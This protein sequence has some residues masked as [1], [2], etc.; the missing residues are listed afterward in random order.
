M[1][2]SRTA[3]TLPAVRPNT[4][5]HPLG[6]RL[7]QAGIPYLFMLPYL[8]AFFFFLFLPALAGAGISLTDW[9]ILGTPNFVGL[10]NYETVLGDRMFWLALKNTLAFTAITVIPMVA[11]GLLLAVLLNQKLRG[12][13]LTRTVIF[14]PYA[15]MV[16]VVG[17]LWR[18][19]YDR[20]FGLANFYITRPFGAAPIAWLTS[21]EWAL[22]AVAITT[23]W[24]QIGTNMVIYLAGLQEIPEELYDAAKVD[25]ANALQRLVHITI[26]S[27]R[28]V[29]IF[30]IPMSVITSMRVFGQV[31]VMT[32]GGPFGSTYT[33]VQHLYAVG[34]VNFRQGEAAAVGVILFALTFLL[35]LL[36]LRYF[37]ALRLEDNGPALRRSRASHIGW[38]FSAVGRGVGLAGTILGTVIM[39]PLNALTDRIEGLLQ[40]H[41]RR[42]SQQRFHWV[43]WIGYPILIGLTLLWT[44]PT[45]WMF[46][47]ALKPEGRV[48]EFPIEWIPSDLTVENFGR[49]VESHPMGTWFLNSLNVALLTTLVALAIY[50]LAAYPLAIHRFR[51]RRFWFLGIMATM[52]IPVEAT[53]IPLFIAL[54]KL[55][56]ADTYFSLI[57]PVAANAFGLYLLVQF[58]QNIPIEL[59][60]SARIDGCNEF[61]V[62]WNIIVPLARPALTTVA[63]LTFM[64]SWNNFVWP[65]V[66]TNS[67]FTRTL[68]VGLMTVMGSITGSP[69]SVQYGIVMAGAV[70]ATLPPM[71]IFIF[72]QRY[73]VQGISMSGIKG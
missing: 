12:R 28:L 73:F 43:P 63:I 31:I 57:M 9:R 46:S 47:T 26:P 33:L 13:V 48:R 22:I 40:A 72:L 8:L 45:V 16:T 39:T 65:F 71:L 35:T 14:L 24:W 52:L 10:D 27:L 23:V 68:P 36:Q 6:M 55:R 50:V 42:P 2:Q 3:T 59:I 70:I 7:K 25:G 69:T 60:D 37:R 11:G 18:W 38:L 62:L 44:V 5:G 20:N 29:H 53:M 66:V 32:Q 4:T 19:I 17:V 67:D 30:V 34:W 41:R 56:I 49:V 61:M 58:F 51:G 1:G 64:A 15:I 54:A 21:P